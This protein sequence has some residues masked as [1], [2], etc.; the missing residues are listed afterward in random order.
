VKTVRWQRRKQT[1]GAEVLAAAVALAGE[2]GSLGMRLEDVAQRAGVSKGTI[3]RYFG[4]RTELLAAV[5]RE[6]LKLLEDQTDPAVPAGCSSSDHLRQAIKSWWLQLRDA[7]AHGFVALLMAERADFP[8]LARYCHQRTVARYR[9]TIA[10]I[11]RNAVA[12]GEF[13]PVDTA[14]A[15]QLLMTPI[16]ALLARQRADADFPDAFLDLMLRGLTT[17]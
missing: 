14:Q 3:Y 15:T 1:R 12:S 16:F 10:A 7:R 8:H 4:T 2:R 13:R 5:A 9:T 6:Q 17:A 11:V